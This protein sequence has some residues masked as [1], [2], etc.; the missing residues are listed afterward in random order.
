M[1]RA[2]ILAAGCGKRAKELTK[3][4]PKCMIKVSGRP[5]ISHQTEKFKQ[6]N[7]T[8]IAVVGGYFPEQIKDPLITQRFIND[9]WQNSNMVRSLLMAENWLCQHPCIVT[10]GDVLFE[11]NAI[12][13]LT[14]NNANIAVTSLASF[15]ET[16]NMRF[17]N[18]LE[19][20]ESFRHRSGK[21]IEIGQPAKSMNDIQGQFM[22]IVKFTPTGWRQT[23]HVLDKL[24]T[25]KIDRIDMTGLLNL[26]VS[27]NIPVQTLDYEGFWAE[28]DSL[29]DYRLVQQQL[30]D[31]AT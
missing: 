5:I 10:Y 29:H 4:K 3:Q 9:R 31:T 19:D 22:G 14:N 18:P 8:E 11:T 2:I 6:Q 26:M 21:L 1:F 25:S 12:N 28:I 16:W 24:S 23:R 30:L 7:I 13:L 17:S 20:I 15:Q 27:T